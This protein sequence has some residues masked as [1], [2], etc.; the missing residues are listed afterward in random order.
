MGVTTDTRSLCHRQGW[1]IEGERPRFLGPGRQAGAL[2]DWAQTS[3]TALEAA[4]S[5]RGQGGAQRGTSTDHRSLGWPSREPRQEGA[6]ASPSS[7]LWHALCTPGGR[8]R[9][10]VAGEPTAMDVSVKASSWPRPAGRVGRRETA[11]N[12][13]TSAACPRPRLVKQLYSFSTGTYV[14]SMFSSPPGPLLRR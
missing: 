2:G 3:G 14:L 9:R 5:L 11:A 13:P 7:S 4:P 12:Q 10:G 8:T 6:I 1:R